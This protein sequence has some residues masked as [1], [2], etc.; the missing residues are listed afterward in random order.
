MERIPGK[1]YKEA[2][3]SVKKENVELEL[4]A[5]CRFDEA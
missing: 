2:K 3:R 4:R 5:G 1:G